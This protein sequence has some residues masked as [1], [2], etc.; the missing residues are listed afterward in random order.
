M[1]TLMILVMLVGFGLSVPIAVSVG[2]AALAGMVTYTSMPLT[3]FAQQLYVALDKYPLVAVPLFILAGNLMEGAGISHRIVEF[4]K[5]CVGGVKGGLAAS[6][7]LTCMIFAA[8][9]GSSIATTFAVGAIMIPA[10]TRNNYPIPFSAALQ[11]TS[12]E[13]GVIIPPSIPLILYAVSAEVSIGKLFMA[14]IGPGLLIGVVLMI[15]VLIWVRV[16]GRDVEQEM[17]IQPLWVSFKA[18]SVSLFMPVVVL[19]GIYGG[20]FTPTEAAAVAVVYALIVGLFVHRELRWS[21]IIPIFRRAMLSSAGILMIIAAAGVFSYLIN[22]AGL[23]AALGEWIAGT[24]ASGVGF[25][26]LVTVALFLIGMFLETSASIIILTPILVPAAIH[27]GIDPIHF[28]LIMIV[29]LALGMITPPFGVNLYAACQVA[30]ISVERVI[31]WLSMF[32]LVVFACLLC[33][34]FIPGI[35]MFLVR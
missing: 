33:I 29:N 34:T 28:G 3:I 2:G 5:S 26:L 7:V 9:S 21:A 20:I 31:P 30:E 23:P 15:T 12:A 13:L 19:G 8:V 35:S 24:I 17:M 11:A 14:G 1:A 32:V 4:A 27:Y 10:L 22:R 16:K 18:A 25:L 6:C